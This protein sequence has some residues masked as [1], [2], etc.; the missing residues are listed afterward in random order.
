M[1]NRYMFKNILL[2]L[3]LFILFGAGCSEVEKETAVKVKEADQTTKEQT[4]QKIMR[5]L[6]Q[7]KDLAANYKQAVIKTNKGDI[8]VELFGD[9]LPITV[10][11]FLNLSQQGFYDG[12]KFHRVIKDF[13]IQG[14]DPNT[15][16]D[17]VYEYGTGGPDYRFADEFNPEKLVKGSLAMAN[18]GPDTNG[19]QFFIVTAVSTPWLDGKHTNFGF[20]VSGMEV[21]DAIE[22][23]DTD[24]R[25]LPLEAVV[26]ERIELTNDNRQ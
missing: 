22:A 12:T 20:V 25:D 2:I 16:T 19:S 9:I 11:N 3:T 13:M 5:T 18:S 24:G 21:V 26:I 1:E 14:G 23:V 15:K 10:N 6:P 7:H 8:I 4:G 17:N